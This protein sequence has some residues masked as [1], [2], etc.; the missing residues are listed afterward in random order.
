MKIEDAIFNVEEI[1]AY[2]E[3]IFKLKDEHKEALKIA[4]EA[5]EKQIPMEPVKSKMPRYG[6]GYVYHDWECPS[7]GSFIAFEPDVRGLQK[8]YRCDRCGQR[9]DVDEED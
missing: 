2:T 4:L 9:L 3:K 8:K 5:M 6:M 7:C 1:I